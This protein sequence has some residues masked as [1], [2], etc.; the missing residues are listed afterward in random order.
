MVRCERIG[1]GLDHTPGDVACADASAFEMVAAAT[2][3]SRPIVGLVS[4][5]DGVATWTESGPTTGGSATRWGAA[6]PDADV[7]A[8]VGTGSAMPTEA[9]DELSTTGGVGAIESGDMGSGDFRVGG[10]GFAEIGVAVTGLGA[11][12]AATEAVAG[13]LLTGAG[14]G[15]VA[16]ACA[17]VVVTGVAGVTGCGVEAGAVADGDGTIG[18]AAAGGVGV[19][20]VGVDAG[21]GVVA[22]AGAGTAG[23]E[24]GG[25]LAFG[26][27]GRNRSGSRYP[28]CSDATRMPR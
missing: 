1:R 22:G 10:V 15:W 16:T 25:W 20:A 7:G 21:A 12:V 26:R 28:S 23:D 6:D 27:D 19:G 8:W 3:A 5:L 11:G 13:P 4:S 14:S 17:P 9:T 24:G 2:A 18:A